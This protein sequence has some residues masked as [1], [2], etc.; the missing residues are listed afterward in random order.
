MWNGEHRSFY[1]YAAFATLGFLV[2]VTFFNGNSNIVRYVQ[3]KIE[4][5]RQEKRIQFYQDKIEEMN[6]EISELK[7]NKD[8]LERFARENF[9]FAAPGDDVYLIEK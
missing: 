8:S 9:H 3:A 6:L 1:R 4:L 5:R 7:E 2:L